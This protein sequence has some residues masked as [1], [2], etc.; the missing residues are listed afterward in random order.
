MG[1][2]LLTLLPPG[3]DIATVWFNL[4]TNSP[5]IGIDGTLDVRRRGWWSDEIAGT[6]TISFTRGVDTMTATGPFSTIGE[7]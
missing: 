2:E 7:G 1:P 6:F 3:N 5:W 4:S